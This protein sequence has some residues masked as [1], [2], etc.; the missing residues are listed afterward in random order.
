MQGIR[1]IPITDTDR[2]NMLKDIGVTNVADLFSDIPEHLMLKG[3]LN[4]P[5]ALTER[6]ARDALQ[7]IAEK[8]ADPRL[9]TSFLGAGAY[10]HFSPSLVHQLLLLPG[11]LKPY[12]PYHG[13]PS[14]GTLQT[15]YEFQT[16]IAQLTDMEIANASLYEGGTALAEA[17]MMARRIKKPRRINSDT[18]KHA[19]RF[20]V[21]RGVHPMYRDVLETYAKPA[22]LQIHEM[23]TT[24]GGVTRLPMS[25]SLSFP[26]E[27]V[28]AVVVQYPNYFG[29]VENLASAR[30]Y[31]DDLGALLIVVVAE[32]VALGILKPPGHFG[33]DIVVGEGQ[34]LGCPLG[35]GGPYLGLLATKK[36]YI[37]QMPGRIIGK[38]KEKHGDKD[39][40]VVALAT[41][42]QHIRREKATSNIC[43][44]Q[45][46]LAVCATI[47]MSLYGKEGLQE[48]SEQ[49]LQKAQYAK[50]MISCLSAFEV[51]H[52]HTFNEFV[53][54][55]KEPS[56][57]VMLDCLAE[58]KIFG[59]VHLGGPYPELNDAFLVCV[60]DMHTKNDIDYFVHTLQKMTNC[61]FN[62]AGAPSTVV[63]V[64]SCV[65]EEKHVSS[66]K[67]SAGIPMS[68]LQFLE[69]PIFEKSSKG[70]HGV[71]LPKLDVPRRPLDGLF[72][73]RYLR[74]SIDGFPELSEP[75][76]AKHFV[77][78]ANL[79]ISIEMATLYPLG[80]CTMKDNPRFHEDIARIPEF[81]SLHPMS[82]VSAA[83]GSLE[84]MWHLERLLEEISGMHSVTLAPA[85]GA[86]GELTGLMMIKSALNA[87]EENRT[88]ILIPDS[89]HGTNPASAAQCGFTPVP[90]KSGPDGR[91]S[92]NTV[93]ELMDEDVAGIMITNPN[94]LG[95]FESEIE[96]IAE[97]VH[98]KGGFVYCDGA[99]LNAIIGMCRPGDMGV[100]VLHMNLHKTFSTPHGGGGPGAGPVGVSRSLEPF[101]PIPRI[102]KNGKL[103]DLRYDMPQ[104]IGQIRTFYG[105]FLVCLRAYAYILSYGKEH[106]HEI[107]ETSVLSANYILAKLRGVYDAPYNPEG[108]PCKHECVFSDTYQRARGISTKD[109]AKRLMDYG[110]HPP[111][112]YFPLIVPNAIMI[113]PT[114]TASKDEVDAFVDAMIAIDKETKENP[115]VILSAPHL[116]PV[117]RLEELVDINQKGAFRWEPE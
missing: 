111:T 35:F 32:P 108:S 92:A 66:K 91:I 51:C 59:G 106:L 87:R 71:D 42:E 1:Y 89:A 103:F 82:P 102:V 24:G 43:T 64:E 48:L 94:T 17:I 10:E 4:L 38:T 68:G 47:W 14:Q 104:S 93:A 3:N 78:L 81:A 69:P 54:R 98:D 113:E 58:S 67:R 79:N 60:T 13:E 22:N 85:A 63:R 72:P 44:N 33:A 21:S 90:V 20:L 39:A 9:Y 27:E 84:V 115:E 80:S 41:R 107:A 31:A 73:Y 95:L 117:G 7:K 97:V 65:T 75:E 52:E 76:V 11:V 55:L 83:Q 6:E 18:E 49:N 116:T 40:Y 57:P 34:S 25:T 114:E 53:V 26:K 109:I 8:N 61:E 46:L 77:R 36:E 70:K 100:D 96:K 19:T 29:V 86:Q 62:P 110:F 15:L 23:P 16:L 99:N 5:S 2:R 45:T 105:N 56:V 28:A 50:E 12:T 74:E 88:K 37:K 112:V 101:L 30:A